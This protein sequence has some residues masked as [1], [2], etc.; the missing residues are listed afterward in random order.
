MDIAGQQ[1][2]LDVVAAYSN[3]VRWE[4]R[5]RL[6]LEFIER[7]LNTRGVRLTMVEC[8]H[9]ER[10]FEL[11]EHRGMNLVRV[12]QRSMLWNKENLLNIGIARLP[13]N[14]SYVAWLDADIMFRD[15][16]WAGETIHALQHYDVIQPWS[17]AYDLGPKGEHVGGWKSFCYQHR[18]GFR[19]NCRTGDGYVFGHP[20]YAWAARRRALDAV[21]G[22]IDTG[23]LGAGDHHMAYSLIGRGGETTSKD[24]LPATYMAPIL[25]WQAF[26]EEAIQRNI[27]Y[28]RGTLEHFWHGPKPDRRYVDRWKIL[29]R[30]QFD[31]AIDLR[32]TTRWVYEL[33]GNKPQLRD[34]LDAYFRQR[35]EDSNECPP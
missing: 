16:H 33:A 19:V 13:D 24:K 34:D 8:A 35:N 11:P 12:R 15:P 32:R 18:R 1:A 9:G 30:N 20:G 28:L 17:D 3:P 22:L 25:R 14:W 23:I 4:S 29:I 7:M 31:P 6:T 2:L 27:G 5:L 26:A 21:G 10:H